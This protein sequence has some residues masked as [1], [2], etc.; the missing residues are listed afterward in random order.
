MQHSVKAKS[1]RSTNR[2]GQNRGRHARGPRQPLWPRACGGLALVAHHG[3]S[4]PPSRLPRRALILETHPIPSR[5]PA[6]R[7]DLQLGDEKSKRARWRAENVRRRHNYIPFLFNFLK[8]LAEK[9]KLKG[10]ID[11]AAMR[12]KE[13]EAAAKEAGGGAQ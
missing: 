11:A 2:S 8:L 5:N 3:C 4:R 10:L 9:G 12:H 7:I 13:K 1:W 6:C